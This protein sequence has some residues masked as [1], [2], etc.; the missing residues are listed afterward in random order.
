[1][2]FNLATNVPLESSISYQNLA[3]ACKIPRS[4]VLRLVR[5]AIANHIFYEPT[6]GFVAQTECS[7]YLAANPGAR[8]WLAQVTEDMW[9]ATVRMVDAI[10]KWPGSE[11]PSESGFSLANQ[12]NDPF[13]VEMSK[14]PD[15]LQRF[16][17]TMKFFQESLPG[18]EVEHVVTGFD[19]ST[20][21]N[22]LFV[23]VGGSHGTTALTLARKFPRI[24]CVVQ[25]LPEVIAVASS[26]DNANVQDLDSRVTFMAHDFFQEQPVK[27]A[28]V[29]FFRMVFH[30]WSD[31][32]CIKIIHSHIPALKPGARIL[33]CD[34]CIPG[35]EEISPHQS[36]H[37]RSVSFR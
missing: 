33:V 31:K 19:W 6:A 18:V 36:R 17:D 16:K 35:F 22:G 9:P 12:T 1:M 20:V 11:E 25:D 2:R 21:E 7:R 5:H 8:A 27:G 24:T 3:E 10:E 28:D 26:A 29:Y 4:D 15:R 13:Y 37:A 34:I 23:D 14:Q 30:N 32:Y